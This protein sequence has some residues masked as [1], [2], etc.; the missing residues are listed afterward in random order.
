M[1]TR[2]VTMPYVVSDGQLPAIVTGGVRTP[3][4][5]TLALAAVVTQEGAISRVR[6]LQ[7]D[8]SDTDLQQ[9]LSR[10]VEDTRSMPARSGGAPVA[11]N[12]VWLLEHTTVRGDAPL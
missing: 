6:V 3:S 12:I 5:S 4:R 1:I 2:G 9:R 7:P 8:V 11:V 10:L